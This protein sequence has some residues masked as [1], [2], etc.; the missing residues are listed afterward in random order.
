MT[1]KHNKLVIFCRKQH[2]E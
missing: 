1:D 2:H